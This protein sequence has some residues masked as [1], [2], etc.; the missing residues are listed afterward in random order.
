ML[1]AARCWRH[2]STAEARVARSLQSLRASTCAGDAL[3][4]AVEHRPSLPIVL[5]ADQTRGGS[6]DCLRN[7]GGG[8]GNA[9]APD[10][11]SGAA[12]APDANLID[13]LGTDSTVSQTTQSAAGLAAGVALQLGSAA[14]AALLLLTAA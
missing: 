9:P 14:V 5:S 6:H 8:S 12:S 11:A 4:V 10:S 3:Q 1:S 13:N 7:A 2:L